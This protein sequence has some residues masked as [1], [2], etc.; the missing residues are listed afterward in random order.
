[1]KMIEE[2]VS[3]GFVWVISAVLASPFD[4][5]IDLYWISL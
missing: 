3:V 2:F 5:D 4:Q 1:M